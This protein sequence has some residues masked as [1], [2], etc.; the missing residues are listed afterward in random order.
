MKAAIV[1]KP[2]TLPV[3]ADFEEP[4]AGPDERV[5][6]VCAAALSPLVR[7]RA[8]G[9]HYNASGQFPLVV[10][11]DGIGRLD[12]GQKVY[13]FVPRA[14]FGAMG[15][16]TVVPTSRIIAVPDDL[17][18]VRAAALANPGMSSWAAFTL[19]ARLKPGETVLVNGA[20]GSS[21]RLAVPIARHLGAGK[22]I[23][24]GRNT[25]A[26]AML[27][28]DVTIPLTDD[29][30]QF[31]DLLKEQFAGGIDV[32]VDYLWGQ[33]AERILNAVAKMTRNTTPMRFV[34]I[35]TM[36][37]L[38]ITLPGAILRSSAIELLG[39]GLGSITLEDLVA[40][41]GG[42][43]DAAIPAGL[44]LTTDSVPLSDVTV[45]WPRNDVSRIV[46]TV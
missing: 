40:S 37:G 27:G 44:T 10:G 16:R 43:L 35:G 18:D 38:D 7:S 13:F 41:V 15:E 46:F 23:A 4:V 42:M 33:S 6:S 28:A 32:V 25:E 14:P 31:E 36:S 21:G 30:D 9:K 12:D 5:I 3:Y 2:G 8:A 22:V 34:Q 1:T 11:V 39:S 24:T 45:A 17:D 26:L 20:T 29:T 19:R